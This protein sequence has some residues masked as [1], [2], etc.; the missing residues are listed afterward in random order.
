MTRPAWLLVFL[1]SCA[2]AAACDGG[3]SAEP[4]DLAE[5]DALTTDGEL[6]S[7]SDANDELEQSPDEDASEMEVVASCSE[8]HGFNGGWTLSDVAGTISGQYAVH[9]GPSSVSI[10]RTPTTLTVSERAYPD[11]HRDD[12]YN[13]PVNPFY[14]RAAS[15][16]IVGDFLYLDA[17]AV[18]AVG[19]TCCLTTAAA[20]SRQSVSTSLAEGSWRLVQPT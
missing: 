8:D 18:E 4:K 10:V 3:P 7:Q 19:T 16:V 2:F 5:A 15:F 13:T 14:G 11:C 12:A 17:S 9:C 20:P 1:S 6:D